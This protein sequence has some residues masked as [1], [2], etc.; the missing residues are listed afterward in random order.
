MG[1]NFNFTFDLETLKNMLFLDRFGGASLA[2][3]LRSLNTGYI[4]GQ[5]DYVVRVRRTN[6]DERS[7]T[8]DEITDGTLLSWVG[9]SSTDNGFVSIWYDQSG[10]GKN[11]TNAANFRQ[12]KIVDGGVLVTSGGN[13]AI[14]RETKL[15]HI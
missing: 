2:Y 10:N 6:Q 1:V 13:V 5:P 15:I 3:S 9:T 14:N 11:A 4:S 7:F 12:P 8:A